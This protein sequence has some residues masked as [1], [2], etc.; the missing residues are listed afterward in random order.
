MN[1]C[2][3]FKKILMRTWLETWFNRILNI[4]QGHIFLS[5]N[6]RKIQKMIKYINF[7]S[8]IWYEAWYNE[9]TYQ[10]WGD[11]DDNLIGNMI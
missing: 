4:F 6:T 1:S 7:K 5:K 11:S 9:S 10:I 8:P 3:K 2:I